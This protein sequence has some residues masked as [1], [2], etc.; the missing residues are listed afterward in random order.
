MDRHAGKKMIIK[1]ISNYKKN[2]NLFG[3]IATYNF[4]FWLWIAFPIMIRSHGAFPFSFMNYDHSASFNYS[5]FFSFIFY[6]KFSLAFSYS[7]YWAQKKR[8][9]RK[10]LNP[11]EAQK[12]CIIREKPKSLALIISSYFKLT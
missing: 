4:F 2:R 9:T 3:L 8:V 1:Q 11:S 5:L 12:H 6:L 7:S 10:G